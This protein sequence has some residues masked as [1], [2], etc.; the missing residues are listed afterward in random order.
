MNILLLFLV[1]SFTVILVVDAKGM[2][3]SRRKKEKDEEA[4]ISLDSSF[5]A[6]SRRTDVLNRRKE[7]DKLPAKQTYESTKSNPIKTLII[8]YLKVVEDLLKSDEF[9]NYVTPES[10]QNIFNQI[11]QVSNYPELEAILKSPEF[12]NPV[13]LKQTIRDGLNLIKVNAD[14]IAETFTNPEKLAAVFEKLPP[15]VKQIFESIKNGDTSELKEIINNLTGLEDSHKEL[16]NNLLDGNTNIIS[17]ALQSLIGDSSKIEAARLQFK[18]N[19]A[20]ATAMGISD[21]VLDDPV[22]WAELMNKGMDVLLG[23]SGEAS[24]SRKQNKKIAHSNAV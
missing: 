12:Q 13:V 6:I 5:E 22:L 18:S 24:N 20:M 11:P 8:T 14:E 23:N 7:V 17:D 1:V 16:I 21:E 3:G 19:P 4:E 9:D 2:W 10:I 15:E